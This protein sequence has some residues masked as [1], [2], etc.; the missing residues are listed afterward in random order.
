MGFE[1]VC[2]E[3]GCKGYEVKSE[4]DYGFDG[5]EEYSYIVGYYIECNKCGNTMDL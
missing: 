5:E 1:V 2:L 3:C 4:I